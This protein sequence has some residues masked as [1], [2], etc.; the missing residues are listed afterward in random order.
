MLIVIKAENPLPNR[1]EM[2]TDEE[3]VESATEHSRNTRTG[4]S[5]NVFRV[6]HKQNG[7]EEKSLL[8]RDYYPPVYTK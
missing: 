6:K 4:M 5:I 7:V 3:E 1:F 8:Y 2:L